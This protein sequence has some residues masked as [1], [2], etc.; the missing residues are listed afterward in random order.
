MLADDALARGNGSRRVLSAIA[1]FRR[2]SQSA[3]YPRATAIDTFDRKNMQS[4][5]AAVVAYEFGSVDLCRRF[6]IRLGNS[7]T[8]RGVLRIDHN[9]G[10]ADMLAGVWESIDP[11]SQIGVSCDIRYTFIGGAFSIPT[12]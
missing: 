4:T 12:I 6:I 8:G 3:A 1:G 11:I 2:V 9:D 7:L 5:F 10:G